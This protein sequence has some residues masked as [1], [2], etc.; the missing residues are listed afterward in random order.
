MFS[1]SRSYDDLCWRPAA[2]AEDTSQFYCSAPI[3]HYCW[4]NA[5]IYWSEKYSHAS[6]DP[7]VSDH[8]S[9]LCG[10]CTKGPIDKKSLLV[11]VMS[12][13]CKLPSHYLN[14]SVVIM[15]YDDIWQHEGSM[16]E[17][18]SLQKWFVAVH[19]ISLSLVIDICIGKDLTFVASWSCGKIMICN[20]ESEC[21]F[22][23]KN[24]MFIVIKTSHW[25]T[26]TDGCLQVI[27]PMPW[28]WFVTSV[29]L[30]HDLVAK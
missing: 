19:I 25:L 2:R 17:R 21:V 6:S 24:V 1:T 23:V 4:Q 30:L 18:C 5:R 3:V 11:H 14:Q 16:S 12:W 29:D 8:M 28:W 27:T 20:G 26:S 15:V 13:Y 10:Y 9:D 22:L 7:F